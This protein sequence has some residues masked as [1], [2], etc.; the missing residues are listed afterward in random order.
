[1]KM[2]SSQV[3]WAGMVEVTVNYFPSCDKQTAVMH[4]IDIFGIISIY[5]AKHTENEIT[6]KTCDSD[7]YELEVHG[8][9]C[10]S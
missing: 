6:A 10:C 9:I 8:L 2:D 5:K 1:M 4:Y 7:D 3:S